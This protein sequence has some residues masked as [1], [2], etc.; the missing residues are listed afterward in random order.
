MTST[1]KTLLV[2]EIEDKN[3]LE[4]YKNEIN[5]ETSDSGFDLFQ[6]DDVS[7][8]PSC[9]PIS[10]SEDRC[11]H[12][13]TKIPLGVKAAMYMEYE[14][15]TKVPIGFMLLPRSSTGS[16]TPLRLANSVGIIDSGYRGELIACVD[17]FW[18]SR[19]NIEKYQRLFQIVPF[20]GFGVDKI[21]FDKVDSTQ[22]GE[23]GFGSTGK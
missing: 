4:K 17:N 12:G 23:G 19:Y 10:E 6:P 22:R 16:K 14:N 9:F 3:L 20:H 7:V 13:S 11:H 18:S 15:G 21:V 1:F 8:L 2:L 5:T